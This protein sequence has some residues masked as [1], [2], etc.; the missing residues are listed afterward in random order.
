MTP[1]TI[2]QIAKSKEGF[3]Y[4]FTQKSQD[5]SEFTLGYMNYER[6]PGRRSMVFRATTFNID[7]NFLFEL[8]WPPN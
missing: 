6:K 1:Q 3:D 8:I 7:E 5:H 2:A 4:W